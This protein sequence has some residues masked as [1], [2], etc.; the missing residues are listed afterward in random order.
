MEHG[1]II[2]R[3][4]LKDALTCSSSPVNHLLEIIELA[5]SEIIS[6]AECKYR[7]SCTGTFPA[8]SSEAYLKIRLDYQFILFG[9]ISEPSVLSAPAASRAS[10]N[11]AFI[12]GFL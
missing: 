11:F 6:A 8:A 10:S 3:E 5:H 2:D 1:G 12:V 7:N 9:N 4:K